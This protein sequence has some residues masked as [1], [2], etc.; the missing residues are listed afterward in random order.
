MQATRDCR[1]QPASRNATKPP[2]GKTGAEFPII[3]TEEELMSAWT[4]CF[5]WCR[6][7]VLA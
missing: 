2:I 4:C 1:R 3:V 7:T 6:F 5:G